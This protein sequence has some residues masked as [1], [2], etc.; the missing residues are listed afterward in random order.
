HTQK[1]ELEAKVTERTAQLALERDKSDALLA[2]ILPRA[3]VDELAAHGAVEPR[4]H[5]E[6]SIL[7]TDFA[8][9]TAAVA[10]IPAKRLVQE[11]DEVFRRFDEIVAMHGL[12]KIK[13]IGDAY[14]AAGGLPLP[15]GDHAGRCVSAG[16]AMCR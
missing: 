7:F 6:V 13:T 15:C 5:E 10:T 14:M 4:R 3:I 1:A 16:L 8:G 12:E 2:N 11:L 9:F